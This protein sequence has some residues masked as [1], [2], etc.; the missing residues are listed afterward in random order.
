MIWDQVTHIVQ[1]FTKV[2]IT[3]G[4][5]SI[6]IYVL[7]PVSEGRYPHAIMCKVIFQAEIFRALC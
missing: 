4:I 1:G 7:I 3:S 5:S 6:I 2:K